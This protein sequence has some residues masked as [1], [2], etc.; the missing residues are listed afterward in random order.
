MFL[1]WFGYVRGL[2]NAWFLAFQGPWDVL[3]L[4]GAS[5]CPLLLCN[6]DGF[7]LFSSVLWVVCLPPSIFRD[8]VVGL[9]TRFWSFW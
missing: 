9:S 3:S 4:L 7:V 2:L 8:P 1:A 6:F 5:K